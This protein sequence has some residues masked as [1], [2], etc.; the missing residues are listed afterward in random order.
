MED[1][2]KKA[3]ELT[4]K[5]NTI[6][7]ESEEINKHQFTA[8]KILNREEEKEREMKNKLDQLENVKQQRL[9]ILQGR[10]KDAYAAIM[11]LR[12][13]KNLFR[14]PIYEPI[15]L[16]VSFK[17]QLSFCLKTVYLLFLL[18]Q[19]GDTYNFCLKHFPIC[20]YDR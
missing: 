8:K 5:S 16:E 15:M 10:D 20:F 4:S 11:W 12:K 1:I 9:Q 3:G 19:N 18:K 14:N 7:S 13:N 17:P 2:D 6:R